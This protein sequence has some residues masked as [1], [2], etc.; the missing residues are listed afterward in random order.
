MTIL[1]IYQ[2]IGTIDDPFNPGEPLHGGAPRATSL[3][4]AILRIGTLAAGIYSLINFVLAGIDFISSGGAPE[5]VSRAWAKIYNSLIGLVIVVL[6]FVLAA[7]L[8]LLL[9]N[10]PTALL[11][12]RIQGP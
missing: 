7:L 8:G 10:D 2:L 5:K 12:P 11:S 6:S 3:L 9:F 4:G 1:L